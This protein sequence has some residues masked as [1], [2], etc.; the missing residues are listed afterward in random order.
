MR[1]HFVNQKDYL[2]TLKSYSIMVCQSKGYKVDTWT[3][4]NQDKRCLIIVRNKFNVQC[5]KGSLRKS[6]ISSQNDMYLAKMSKLHKNHSSGT[7][8]MHI[9]CYLAEW[10]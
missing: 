8:F 5:Q 1:V 3:N 7:L 9:L 10:Q 6:Q 2:S 4:A